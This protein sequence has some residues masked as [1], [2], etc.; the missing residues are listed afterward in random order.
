MRPQALASLALVTA[1]L[2]GCLG[3]NSRNQAQE[4]VLDL[5]EHARF[6]RMT[7]AMSRVDDAAR[8]TFAKQH[9]GWGSQVQIADY[10]VVGLDV[11][12][13]D[14]AAS[15]VR[16]SWYRADGE[17]HGTTLRQDWKKGKGDWKLVKEERAD[18][19][20]G[21]LGE[22]VEVLAPDAPRSTAQFPSLRIGASE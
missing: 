12:D 22:R 20:I 10:E 18:G 21:L 15:Y 19:D 9:A 16:I 7:V 14:T 13:K 5:N 8:E 11:G 3:H 1:L 17:L 6:G 2:A 4:A